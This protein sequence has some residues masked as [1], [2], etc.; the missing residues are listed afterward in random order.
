MLCYKYP[1]RI[2][3]GF[4][5]FHSGTS[6]WVPNMKGLVALLKILKWSSTLLYLYNTLNGDGAMWLM[7]KKERNCRMFLWVNN[8]S[9]TKRTSLK[10]LWQWELKFS[11]RADIECQ[12]P[13]F[14]F[15]V[16]FTIQFFLHLIITA[17]QRITSHF[18]SH[19]RTLLKLHSLPTT[20]YFF[21][22]FFLSL[23]YFGSHWTHPS[24]SKA[25]LNSAGNFI[26]SF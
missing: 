3:V 4:F 25:F 23:F 24:H 9:D 1:G 5:K 7:L 8:Y 22:S 26:A 19:G 18:E 20:P 2:S 10:S 17:N 12:A 16:Q 14:Y 13:G 15:L 6:A 11:F 21:F